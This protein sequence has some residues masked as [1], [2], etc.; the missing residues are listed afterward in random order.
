MEKIN[1]KLEQFE[2]PLDLLLYL[3]SKNKLDIYE[4][5]IT[6]LLDQYMEHIHTMQETDM[7]I[8]SEFLDMAARLVYIKTVSLLPK[9]DE[10]E[11]LEQE[12][13]GQLI[14]YK[15]CREAAQKL[16]DIALGFDLFVR[17]PLNIEPDK[18]YDRKHNA[19]ILIAAYLNAVGRGN[20]KLPPPQDIFS[21][22]VKREPVSV[23]SRVIY[24]LKKL[25]HNQ[26]IA[27]DSL[28]QQADSR[29]ELVSTFMAVLE[30]IKADRIELY[31]DEKNNIS[32]KLN[33]SRRK[34]TVIDIP[35]E[36]LEEEYG[37]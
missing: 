25:R 28:F 5:F 34:D 12:L 9:Y 21:P 3:I 36:I 35:E 29:S 31:N 11:Q 26:T 17:Q 2:G 15:A 22:I 7:D 37:Y 32:L 4:I 13:K 19:D 24:I 16:K 33:A 1:Y 6:D 27:Y 8:A 10:G 14:E 30:L 20:R 23:S 18:V